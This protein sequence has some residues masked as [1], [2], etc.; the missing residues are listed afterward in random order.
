MSAMSASP[1]KD[2]ETQYNIEQ[3]LRGRELRYAAIFGLCIQSGIPLCNILVMKVKD[4][5]DS[6]YFHVQKFKENGKGYDVVLTSGLFNDLQAIAKH[7][8]PDDYVFTSLRDKNKPIPQSTFRSILSDIENE[9]HLENFS[10]RSLTKTFFYSIYLHHG[11][12]TVKDLLGYAS[13]RLAYEYLD[14]EPPSHKHEQFD[15]NDNT[16][17]QISS[18]KA[19]L[20]KIVANMQS[21][22]KEQKDTINNSLIKTNELLSTILTGL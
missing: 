6:V 1:I 16:I 18:I 4:I 3:Y 7:K 17:H 15:L 5:P 14:I 2:N 10:G 13:A 19:N 8:N 22:S 21:L 12:N 20:S 9:F 11:I